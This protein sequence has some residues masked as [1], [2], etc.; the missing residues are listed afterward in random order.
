[1][2]LSVCISSGSYTGSIIDAGLQRLLWHA[3]G[4]TCYECTVRDRHRKVLAVGAP[5]RCKESASAGRGRGWVSQCYREKLGGPVAPV[6]GPFFF[7]DFS[8]L[9]CLELWPIPTRNLHRVVLGQFVFVVGPLEETT[10]EGGEKRDFSLIYTNSETEVA[11]RW[12]CAEKVNFQSKQNPKC[13][14]AC[15]QH[16]QMSLTIRVLSR[17]T[18]YPNQTADFIKVTLAPGN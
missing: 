4:N 13:T 3:D 18:H 9:L 2:C 8:R 12:L 7:M 15:S 16:Q 11:I 6:C 1:M 14:S 5:L 17:C 10:L